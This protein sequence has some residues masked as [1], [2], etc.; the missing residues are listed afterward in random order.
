MD[1]AIVNLSD[2]AVQKCPWQAYQ[3]LRDEAPVYRM[4]DT[5]MYVIS[6]YE[7]ICQIVRD[8]AR[9][10]MQADRSF[11]FKTEAATRYYVDHGYPR[12]TPLSTDP[13]Y[14]TEFRGHLEPFFSAG[15]IRQWE[16]ALR[17]L[18]ESLAGNLDTSKPIDF[19]QAFCFPLPMSVMTILLGLPLEDHKI[20]KQW[21][22]VWVLPFSHAM[23][24][25]QEMYVAEEGIKLQKYILAALDE[26]R[27]NPKDDLFSLLVQTR[28]ED[29]SELTVKEMLGFAEQAV[30]GAN[31]T[32]QNGLAMAMC[33]L[34]ENPGVEAQLRADPGK[35]RTFIEECLRLHS[36]TA[37]M[38]RWT[39]QDVEMHGVT[40]PKGSTVHLRFAAA[41]RDE[42]HFEDP[43]TLDIERKKSGS[44]LAF[45]HAV[46][47]CL[48]APLARLE[49]N[50]S[51]EILLAQRQN[52]RF[53]REQENYDYV[54]G[55]ALRQ[56]EYLWIESDP[57]AAGAA[58]RSASTA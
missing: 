3:T 38:Y 39:T 32:T 11:L 30:V 55:L 12:H 35:I 53:A 16:P 29:G 43:D 37:G 13:P 41:N 57:V 7:D 5:G 6:R 34:I 15:R 10:S 21:T 51:F 22:D 47:H 42:R 45:S 36:P 28:R 25:E 50:L 44:H 20:L 56:L 33:A 2:V 27:R 58:R 17:E 52:F 8:P 40:I 46:H 24:A 18:I 4:P 23:T 1:P 48:G 31:E 54:P 49:L 26:K 14:H 9:F 19:V